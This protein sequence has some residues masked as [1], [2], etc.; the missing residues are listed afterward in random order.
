MRLAVNAGLFL[1][2][3]SCHSALTWAENWNAIEADAATQLVA[4]LRRNADI[5]VGKIVT[6]VGE[7]VRISRFTRDGKELSRVGPFRFWCDL[8]SGMLQSRVEIDGESDDPNE[9]KKS[10]RWVVASP[11]GS[12][13]V[14]PN[15]GNPKLTSDPYAVG[16]DSS[17][18]RLY[19]AIPLAEAFGGAV[20]GNV[21]D[22]RVFF[23]GQLATKLGAIQL[24]ETI[25]HLSK[26]MENLPLEFAELKDGGSTW[27]RIVDKISS[28]ESQQFVFDVTSGVLLEYRLIKGDVTE[29]FFSAGYEEIDGIVIPVKM[30]IR[31]P[32]LERVINV[33]STL[34]N[35][36]I[37]TSRFTLVGLDVSEGDRVRDRQSG[38]VTVFSKE[39]G[40]VTSAEYEN[41]HGRRP[42]PVV[43]QAVASD[44]S[45]QRFLMANL[46]VLVVS[47]IAFVLYRLRRRTDPIDNGLVD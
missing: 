45:R 3:I 36:P 13:S 35:Q 11:E 31:K 39:R 21:V 32:S 47:A 24:A 5:N 15:V 25:E 17:D 10:D 44:S 37:D 12:F 19:V 14:Y 28:D 33:K 22:P 46:G 20:Y 23:V 4:Q 18:S 6:W 42:V 16:W 1:A 40:L 27:L 43:Q 30:T 9:N 7:G 8:E 2:S 41:I 26:M 29:Q 38:K 34:L